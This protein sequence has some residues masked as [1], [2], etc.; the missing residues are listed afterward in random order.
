MLLCE[1]ALPEPESLR[2]GFHEHEVD[3]G[4]VLDERSNRSCHARV[5]G[6][7][8]GAVNGLRERK[9]VILRDVDELDG[10]SRAG[11]VRRVGTRCFVSA[12]LE[13]AS[14]SAATCHGEWTYPKDMPSSP[15]SNFNFSSK[16][17]SMVSEP[18]AN[19]WSTNSSAP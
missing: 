15:C 5:H 17:K 10:I 11:L 18:M 2:E 9:R 8:V 1:E 7:R 19:I 14:T 3:L 12:R 16:D 4:G 13:L 6:G